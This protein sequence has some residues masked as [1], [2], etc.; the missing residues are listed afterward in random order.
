MS[1]ADPPAMGPALASHMALATAD[2][3]AEAQDQK[4]DDIIVLEL[5]RQTRVKW[6]SAAWHAVM[7]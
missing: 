5:D 3:T 7:G 6:V 2:L 4:V 1:H